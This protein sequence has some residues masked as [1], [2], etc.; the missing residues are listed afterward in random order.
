VDGCG[1]QLDHC[2]RRTPG[3]SCPAAPRAGAA[4]AVAR[5]CPARGRA[6]DREA[7]RAA[8]AVAFA[9]SRSSCSRT[10]Q[11]GQPRSAFDLCSMSA[12]TATKFALAVRLTTAFDPC[13]SRRPEA[14]CRRPACCVPGSGT[15]GPAPPA[16]P[17]CV[18]A[19]LLQRDRHPGVGRRGARHLH[20]PHHSRPSTWSVR[21]TLANQQ[22]GSRCRSRH[23]AEA[24]RVGQLPLAVGSN[25]A[26][27][28]I[29]LPSRVRS[30][31]PSCPRVRSNSRTQ[32]A[33][34]RSTTRAGTSPGP[35]TVSDTGLR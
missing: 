4:P 35:C 27:S 33:A 31:R 24:D 8:V 3:R 28:T 22:R 21:P 30:V 2:W 18:L 17:G 12:S 1:V 7:G 26:A 19:G 13:W 5:P 14:A 16:G 20:R 25:C 11:V 23:V 29:C 10:T 15:S 32:P 6:V 34:R 9:A